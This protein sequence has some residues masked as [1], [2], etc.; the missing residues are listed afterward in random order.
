VNAVLTELEGGRRRG[1]QDAD[2]LNGLVSDNLVEVVTLGEAANEWFER[3]VIGRATETLDDGEAASIAYAVEHRALALIDERKANRIC[4]ERFPE[5][6]VAYTV[7]LLAHPI[8]EETLGRGAL[9]DAVFNALQDARMRVSS[10]KTEWVVD[11]IG[12]E[13]ATTCYSLPMSV[14][15]SHRRGVN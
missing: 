2:L 13:R 5:L 11:L 7:D 3:L 1:R 8:L 10:E 15:Y 12:R 6:S 14:R 9:A 4:A